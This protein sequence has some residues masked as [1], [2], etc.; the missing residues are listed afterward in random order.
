VRFNFAEDGEMR[1]ADIGVRISTVSPFSMNACSQLNIL[2][3]PL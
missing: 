1:Y 2:G 3:Q